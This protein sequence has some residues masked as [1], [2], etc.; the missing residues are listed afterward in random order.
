MPADLR[1]SRMEISRAALAHNLN[2]IRNH[3]GPRKIL[4]V[5]KAN[6]YGHGL[7]ECAEVF[8]KAGTDYFGVALVE[9]GIA[10]RKSGIAQPILVF[11]GLTHTQLNDYLDHDLEMTAPSV[12]KLTAIDAIAAR[13]GQKAKVHLKIDTGLGRIGVQWDRLAPFI[14]GIKSCNH[15]DVIGVY[16][17][18]ATAEEKDTSFAQTQIKRFQTA[19]DELRASGITWQIAHLANSA[20]IMQ[21][22]ESYFDMVRPGLALYGVAP[23]RELEN[24]LPLRPAMT[25][26]S[27]VVYFKTLPA[28]SG[29]SYGQTYHTAQQTRIVTLPIGYGDGIHRALS[30]KT[31]VI[32]RGQRHPIA[33]NICMDQLMVDI[34]PHGTA[35]NGDEAILIGDGISV[36]DWAEKIN[37]APH[38]ILTSL[39]M[40]LPRVYL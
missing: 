9:E 28:G 32:I 38:E 17:H 14:E 12:E 8:A 27:S 25:L 15:I 35:Y 6:A 21:L 16:S 31:E 39:N 7:I 20:A 37:T 2:A 23:S 34:G 36:L 10:L 24:T 26:K 22:P 1:P 30:G 5:V 3:I 19:L 4:S 40:R 13:R 33:G 29:I 18:L 11:G